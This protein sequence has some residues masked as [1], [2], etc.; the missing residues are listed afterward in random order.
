M[1]ASQ[2]NDVR[3]ILVDPSLGEILRLQ[4]LLVLEANHEPFEDVRHLD[5]PHLLGL[6]TIWRDAIAVLDTLGWLPASATAD[7]EVAVTAGHMAQLRRL[8]DD[9]AVAVLDCLAAR[10]DVT[11]P[12][13]LDEIDAE[14]HRRRLMAD[15]IAELLQRYCLAEQT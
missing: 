1:S 4:S 7:R 9:E 5:A 6:A 12:D 3:R 10:E 15:E 2:R 14:I 11:S 13:E 8:R